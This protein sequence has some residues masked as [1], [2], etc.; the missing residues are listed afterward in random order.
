MV[1]RWVQVFVQG[2]GLYHA[3]LLDRG[4]L[5]TVPANASPSAI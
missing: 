3:Y 5:D 2:A 4:T 1:V